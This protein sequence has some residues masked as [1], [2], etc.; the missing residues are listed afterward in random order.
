MGRSPPGLSLAVF[1]RVELENIHTW[2]ITCIHTYAF[3]TK[4][5]RTLRQSSRHPVVAGSGSA[6]CRYA[7][8]RGCTLGGVAENEPAQLSL[9]RPARSSAL[10]AESRLKGTLL[11]LRVYPLGAGPIPENTRTEWASLCVFRPCIHRKYA[12]E[13]VRPLCHHLLSRARPSP[14]QARGAISKQPR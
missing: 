7:G 12:P 8:V 13:T 6:T 10:F 2:Y 14:W 3:H 4:R 5:A 9:C 11:P 1:R